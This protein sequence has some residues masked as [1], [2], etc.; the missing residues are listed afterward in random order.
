[1]CLKAVLLL[2]RSQRQLQTR[3]RRRVAPGTLG[4][5]TMVTMVGLE[6]L[7]TQPQADRHCWYGWYDGTDMP[8]TSRKPSDCWSPPTA[9]ND[10]ERI[11][12]RTLACCSREARFGGP[13]VFSRKQQSKLVFWFSLYHKPDLVGPPCAP[14]I[15]IQRA[16]HTKSRCHVG[17]RSRSKL[18]AVGAFGLICTLQTLLEA[19]SLT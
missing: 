17:S 12:F 13:C 16:S 1:V 7:E 15:R 4:E 8:H 19:P 11:C 6:T 9:H 18:C 3:W 14:A 5:R 10:F 2:H